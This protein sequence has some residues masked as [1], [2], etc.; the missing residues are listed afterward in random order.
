MFFHIRTFAVR[1][2]LWLLLLLLCL[3][4]INIHPSPMIYAQSS[5]HSYLLY[6][7]LNKGNR[8]ATVNLVPRKFIIAKKPTVYLTF[9]DGPSMQTPKVLDLLKA[10]GIKASF[11]VLGN[12]AGE[13]PEFI[14][15]MVRDG[16]TIGNH[17]YDHIYKNLY[18]DIA[19]FWRQIQ[20]T[21]NIISEIC[22]VTP[23]LVRAP[24]GTYSNF[25]AFYYYDMDEA[26]YTMMDWNM[27]ST[28]STRAGITAKEIIAHVKSGTLK[29]EVILLMHDGTGHSETVKAL[30]EIIDYFKKRGYA[31][32]PLT[33][34]VKPIQFPLVKSRWKQPYSFDQ[35]VLQ[36]N[37]V[38]QYLAKRN[39]Q[40]AKDDQNAEELRLQA[41]RA[42]MDLLL[43]Y[44]KNN[45]I[46]K[47]EDYI[48]KQEKFMVPLNELADLMQAKWIANEKNRL[49]TI[50]YGMRKVEFDMNKKTIVS[51]DPNGTKT[52]YGLQHFIIQHGMLQV[53]L[54]STVE[55]LGNYI[56]FFEVKDHQ[57]H[58]MINQGFAAQII[59]N[60]SAIF[61]TPIGENV[62]LQG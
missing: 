25:N 61:S 11:F 55:L 42:P 27:D 1:V 29:H 13:H 51:Y 38:T 36:E 50:Y 62:L 19:E 54:R 3:L 39:I 21:E 22:G 34:E 31:F 43:S 9:D 33:K 56:G 48:F 35:F 26:G 40:S 30:P 53:P 46:V 15:R 24:G 44:N 6:E 47:Q 17:S 10:E 23:E 2:L 59:M 45:R 5:N 52:M 37:R 7:Q 4:L 14:R 12:M 41:L 18:S 49:F 8:V 60:C 16:H 58:V 20:K 28:D 57:R 32:A